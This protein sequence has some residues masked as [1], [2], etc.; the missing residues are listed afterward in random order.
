MYFYLRPF[1]G[2]L[3]IPTPP[4]A[5]PNDASMLQSQILPTLYV[6]VKFYCFGESS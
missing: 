5:F 2:G 1:L 4:T 3:L 6:H